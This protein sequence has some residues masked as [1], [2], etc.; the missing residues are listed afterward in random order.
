MSEYVLKVDDRQLEAIRDYMADMLV[1][2]E[3]I[4]DD[5]PVA[6]TMLQQKFLG[7]YCVL[8]ALGVDVKVDGT[9]VEVS[10]PSQRMSDMTVSQ[11]A[12]ALGVSVG[13]VRQLLTSKPQKLAGVKS[14]GVWIVSGESVASYLAAR[15]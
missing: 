14:G 7:A 6:R 13:R 15:R 11:A 8:A 5:E 4:S 12:D 1:A 3:S 10:I 9:D 2:K